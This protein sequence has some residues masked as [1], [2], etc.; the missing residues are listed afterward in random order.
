MGSP[1]VMFGGLPCD[2]IS[3]Q[4][5]SLVCSTG[6]PGVEID[7][8]MKLSYSGNRVCLK[9]WHCIWNCLLFEINCLCLLFIYPIY[10]Y[11]YIICV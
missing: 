6:D 9:V 10:F 1:S 8:D 5:L 7:L 4:Y 11:T 3:Q 2:L